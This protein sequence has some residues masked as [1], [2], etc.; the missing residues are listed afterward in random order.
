MSGNFPQSYG[1]QFMASS[2]FVCEEKRVSANIYK[3]YDSA[4]KNDI[5]LGTFP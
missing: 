3:I 4:K 1:S 2:S 5:S